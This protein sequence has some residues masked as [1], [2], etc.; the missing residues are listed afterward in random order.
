MRTNVKSEVMDEEIN[1]PLPKSKMPS[2]WDDDMRINYLFSFIR[3][4]TV[5]PLDAETKIKF[6]S[7][8]IED[9][10]VHHKHPLITTEE[11]MGIFQRGD[12]L[13]ACLPAVMENMYRNGDLVTKSNF[14]YISSPQTWT[15]WTVDLLVK[16]P[17]VWAF[18]KV[19]DSVIKTSI[20]EDI[21]FV[22]V[23]ACKAIG[24]KLLL[25]HSNK[26]LE[27][28]D[29]A[30][31]WGQSDLEQVLVLVHGLRQEGKAAIQEGSPTLVKL[32][33]SHITDA[34]IGIHTLKK[35]EQT[36]SKHLEQ[37]EA[38]KQGAIEE[39]RSFLAKNMRQA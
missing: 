15:G 7:A 6:W 16:K 1:L 9:W 12:R 39:A 36:L 10:C 29:L 21:P 4:A 17:A 11:L 18:N 33:D 14:T 31:Q 28:S 30:E 24:K 2:C 32:G 34:D 25:K 13:P 23:A 27:L 8:L 35:N 38:E 26:L 20:S 19:K 22:H 5:N 3:P 37:L